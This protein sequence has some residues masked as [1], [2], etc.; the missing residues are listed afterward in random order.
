ME[1]IETS[2]SGA[3][4]AGL[5]A[6]NDRWGLV[7][8]ETCILVHKSLFCIQKQRWGLGQ[9]EISNSYAKVVV[10]NAQSN[11]W[12]VGPIDIH[13]SGPKLAD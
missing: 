6:Q 13:H 12:G 1:P 5:Y 4:H 11:R 9:I 3:N 7:P 2:N 8:I 10:L